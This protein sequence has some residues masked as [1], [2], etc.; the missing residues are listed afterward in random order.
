MNADPHWETAKHRVAQQH[1]AAQAA[2][3]TAAPPTRRPNGTGPLDG[4]RRFYDQHRQHYKGDFIA[5]ARDY[6]AAQNRQYQGDD[7]SADDVAEVREERQ[8]GT[9]ILY[10]HR[11]IDMAQKGIIELSDGALRELGELVKRERDEATKAAGRSHVSRY[12]G[13]PPQRSQATGAPWTM[14]I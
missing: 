2:A 5:A 6:A 9:A 7:D 11:V 3:K 14:W 13:D 8:R 12:R 10:L 1:R 4:A